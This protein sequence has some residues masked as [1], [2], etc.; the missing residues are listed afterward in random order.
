MSLCSVARHKVL[1][2]ACGGTQIPLVTLQLQMLVR[3]V[4]SLWSCQQNCF[5]F[6]SP[7]FGLTYIFLKT[8]ISPYRHRMVY[9][10]C[11]WVGLPFI[12]RYHRA[13]TKQSLTFV[14]SV[15][16]LPAHASFFCMWERLP[17]TFRW[18][19]VSLEHCSVSSLH[20]AGCRV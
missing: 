5:Y 18:L 6:F 11:S 16:S 12:E 15:S 3:R 7:V 2:F 20:N 13:M 10:E 19:S 1:T 9:L 8:I 4:I 17:T 14:V